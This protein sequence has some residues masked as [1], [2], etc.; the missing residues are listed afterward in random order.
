MAKTI[1]KN[2][3][4]TLQDQLDK[5]RRLVS[6]DSYDLS[7]RQL[8][9]MFESGEIS[10]PPEYQRQFIWDETRQSELVES[11]L[12]G[13][14]VPSLFMATN[15]DSTWEIVDGVQRLGT[16]AHFLGTKKL[17]KKVEK[18]SPLKIE[19]LEKLSA[20][21]GETHETLPK[22]IQLMFATR[23]MR[24][25]VLNDKSDMAVRF[26]LFERLNTGGIALTNQEIR[27]CVFRGPYNDDLKRLAQ[28]GNFVK[29]IKLKPGDARNGTSEEYV[30]RYFAFL[31]KYKQFDH[32]VKEFLNSYM[33]DSAKKK[34]SATNERIFKKTFEFIAEELPKGIVRGNRG[35][36]PV[37]L[38]EAIATG[39][40]LAIKSGKKIKRG[41]LI[42]L[43]DDQELRVHTTGATNS[44]KAVTS[45]IEIVKNALIG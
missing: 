36:T 23:P 3:P 25:T 27:N 7:V 17:I 20:M 14:P 4:A 33:R 9:E 8:L 45:R 44:K 5:E 39:C 19:G 35:V 10:I 18:S 40:A 24:V 12:L 2:Y 34:L 38:Y 1:G 15:S 26:D 42:G 30:L 21:N 41:V 16:L 32:S 43:L 31:E 6:F 22:S 28:D 13:I 29:T 37:N 11:V